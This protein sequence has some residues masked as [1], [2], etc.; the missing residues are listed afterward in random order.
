MGRETFSLHLKVSIITPQT[1]SFPFSHL[2]S[3][4]QFKWHIQNSLHKYSSSWF[5]YFHEVV[6]F[7]SILVK[8]STSNFD[9]MIKKK[10]TTN[11]VCLGYVCSIFFLFSQ[12]TCPN[13]VI[14]IFHGKRHKLQ[15][16]SQE[17]QENKL[18]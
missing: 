13:L 2:W 18:G 16:N 11:R 4:Q 3:I 10:S 15:K 17:L 14:E 1:P 5:L 9:T 8:L 6:L 12:E 7:G